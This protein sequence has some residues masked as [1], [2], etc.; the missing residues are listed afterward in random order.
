MGLNATFQT[1]IQLTGSAIGPGAGPYLQDTQQTAP[2][3]TNAPPPETFGLIAGATVIL[4]WPGTNFG[5]TF[6]RVT[7]M[8]PGG[9]TNSKTVLGVSNASVLDITGLPGWTTGSITIPAVS[10]GGAAVY[11]N[12]AEQLIAVYS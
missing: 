10:G 2:T 8:P 1:T 4:V 7:L 9:S 5:F 11:S 12:G 6:S 3:N